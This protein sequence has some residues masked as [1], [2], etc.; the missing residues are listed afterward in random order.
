MVCKK[1][2][3]EALFCFEPAVTLSDGHQATDV[4]ATAM[5]QPNQQLFSLPATPPH[6]GQGS[7]VEVKR[8]TLA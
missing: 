5:S 1:L 3:R 4:I 2:E 8:L 6:L 7:V